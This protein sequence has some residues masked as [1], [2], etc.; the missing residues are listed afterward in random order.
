MQ[1]PAG[2]LQ[3]TQQASAYLPFWQYH[4]ADQSNAF[5]VKAIGKPAQLQP[6]Y[7]D[8]SHSHLM[9]IFR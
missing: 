3:R 1:K 2:T 8:R 7:C 6:V 9:P 5:S 4:P